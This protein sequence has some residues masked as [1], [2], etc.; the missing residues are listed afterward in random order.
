MN[1]RD[2][3]DV[4]RKILVI[5]FATTARKMEIQATGIAISHFCAVLVIVVVIA[6]TSV[7]P[8]TNETI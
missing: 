5:V 4:A 8:A 6:S 7:K 1:G 2:A 3:K